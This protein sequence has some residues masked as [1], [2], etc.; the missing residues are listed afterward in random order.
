M[1]LAT[2]P[3]AIEDIKAGRFIIIVDDE[4]R[5]NEGD[6]AMAAEKITAEA[7]NFMAKHGRG[8][9]CLPIIGERLDELGIPMM[10]GENT[11]KHETAFT[12]SIEAKHRVTTGISSTE[13]EPGETSVTV[14]HTPFTAMLSPSLVSS[15]T[16]W[17]AMVSWPGRAALTLPTSSTIPVNIL[18]PAYIPAYH[19]IVAKTLH[20]Y[21]AQP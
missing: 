2:I 8:L 14:R 19:H 4:G 5:E 11:S 20:L 16:F 12:V 15:S 1:G 10:V 18:S 7:I 9:I 13:K 17:A 3:E 21:M 6:L